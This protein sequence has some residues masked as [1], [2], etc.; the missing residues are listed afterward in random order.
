MWSD[1]CPPSSPSLTVSRGPL[2]SHSLCNMLPQTHQ[3]SSD[4]KVSAGEGSPA[5]N[6]NTQHHRKYHVI[7]KLHPPISPSLYWTCAPLCYSFPGPQKHPLHSTPI[8]FLPVCLSC[9][10]GKLSEANCDLWCIFA[11]WPSL[12]GR[13]T[14]QCPK[15]KCRTVHPSFYENQDTSLAPTL[16]RRARSEPPFS[17]P[18][19]ILCLDSVFACVSELFPQPW[20]SM[21]TLGFLAVYMSF[22]TS[23][24][25]FGTNCIRLLFILIISGPQFVSFPEF[26]NMGNF[27]LHCD[28]G[29][30]VSF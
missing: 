9:V 1:F 10:A 14:C 16:A 23:I 20:V 2:S 28:S 3:T 24:F 5:R 15:P 6:D 7:P 27:M 30:N 29:Q 22:L 19:H 17:K 4:S 12:K 18:A 26:F 13:C 25:H 8:T 21:V 11:S